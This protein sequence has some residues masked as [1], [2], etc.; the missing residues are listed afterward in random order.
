M[1]Q[2]YIYEDDADSHLL[3]SLYQ[4]QRSNDIKKICEGVQNIDEVIHDLRTI[5]YEQSETLDHIT[6]N[7]DNATND[8]EEV[9]KIT[10]KALHNMKF[11]DKLKRNLIW[12][13]LIVIVIMCLLLIFKFIY[14]NSITT[15]V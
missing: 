15:N 11:C 12:G 10:D 8:T 7:I 9:E 6:V 14:S 5:I 13:L 3:D 4:Q 2:N 1:K